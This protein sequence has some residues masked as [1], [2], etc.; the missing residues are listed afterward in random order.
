[1]TEQDEDLVAFVRTLP[2]AC[3]LKG[4]D[5]R[6]RYVNAATQEVF[7]PRDGSAVGQVVHDLFPAAIAEELAAADRRV[8]ELGEPQ[9]MPLWLPGTDGHRRHLAVMKFPVVTPR[10]TLI[11]GLAL[12]IATFS[13][14]AWD[15]SVYQQI[16]NAISDMILVKGPRSKLRWA[17]RAFL[18]A[19]GMTNLELQGLIDAPF[20]E[21]DMTL[22]YIKDDE[23]V[24]TTGR[25]LDIPD[26]PM[27]RADGS[28]RTCHTVKSPIFDDAGH[29]VMTVGVIRD[30][31]EK[32]RLELELRQA[33][34]LESIGRL[35][36]G[37]A[38]EINTPIQFIG[39]QGQFARTACHDLLTLIT[40]YRTLV[41]RLEAGAVTPADLQVVRDA[42]AE[43]DLA[44]VEDRLPA[45]FDAMLEGVQR[46]AQLV[47]A[48]KEFGHPDAGIKQPADL[49][50][51]LRSTVIVASNEHKYVA[52]V[53]LALGELPAVTCNISELKQVFLNLI[54][55]A[56]H[57]IAD[58]A[59]GTRGSIRITSC[60]EGDTAVVSI[61]DTGCGIPEAVRAS[62]FDPFFTTKVV[63]R[64][65]GQGLAI[66]RHIVDKHRDSL[67]FQTELGRGT[68]FQ[69]RIPIHGPDGGA[70][71]PA[72]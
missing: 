24:F 18:E 58:A 55:N 29:V 54:V 9:L 26:E 47:H 8:I 37:M 5:G 53:E 35:A 16:L 14:T 33:Q 15:A 63:G 20:V 51:A 48:L 45:A 17:N 2:A 69:V 34:K 50:A 46:V 28:V 12:D 13:A 70:P 57:A 49:N 21:P 22:Q 39:D 38:H 52:D 59:T 67:T 19:Y 44:Y 64:G 72:A 7:G 23:Q 1:V 68:T 36:A 61:A 43:V 40:H 60:V 6:Y 11:G 3:W 25:A 65:T 41:A 66:A 42:E 71:P 56:A 31:T 30:I 27:T 4:R 10:E 62:I 32:Q